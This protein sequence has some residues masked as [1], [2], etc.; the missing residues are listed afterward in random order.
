VRANEVIA[1]IEPDL[2]AG[3]DTTVKISDSEQG[4]VYTG[5]NY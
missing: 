2:I 4:Y 1:F 3:Y 5:E